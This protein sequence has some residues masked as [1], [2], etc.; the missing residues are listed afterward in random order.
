MAM[1]RW[2]PRV[3][4]LPREEWQSRHRTVTAVVAA[5]VPLLWLYAVHTGRGPAHSTLEVSAVLVA[6]AVAVWGGRRRTRSLAAALGLLICSAV[7]VH[8][9]NGQIE[10]HFHYFVAVALIA[11]YEEWLVY[12]VAVGFVVLQHGIMGSHDPFDVFGE[13]GGSPWV[14]TA[15]HTGFVLCLCAAQ[16]AFWRVNER[17]HARELAVEQARQ[18]SERR[19]QQVIDDSPVGIARVTLTGEYVE[20]NPAMST[21]LGRDATEIVGRDY[22]LFTHPEDL[23]VPAGERT[24]VAVERRTF[25]REKRYVRPDGTE[26]WALVTVSM[27]DDDAGRPAWFLVQAQDVT[28]RRRLRDARLHL[29]LEA[30]GTGSWEW[31]LVAGTVHR[32]ATAARLLGLEADPS[33]PATARLHP[34]DRGHIAAARERAITEDGRFDVEYRVPQPDGSLVWVHSRAELVRDADG[35]PLRLL[36]VSLDVTDRHRA[37]EER[38]ALRAAEQQAAERAIRLQ[39]LTAALAEALTVEE[40]RAALA[41]TAAGM[42]GS[43][44]SAL[45]VFDSSCGRWVG[46]TGSE[47]ELAAPVRDALRDGTPV[48]CP[49]T[50]DQGAAMALPLVGHGVLHGGWELRWPG[51]HVRTPEKERFLTT[52]AA[53]VGTTLERAGL[54]EAQREVAELLQRSLLPDRVPQPDGVVTAARYLPAGRAAQVGGDWYDVI[55]LP[56]GRIG[57]AIGDVSG[58]GVQAAALMGQLRGTLRAYAL[59]GRAPGQVLAAVNRAAASIAG[60]SPEQL[61]TAAYA[62]VDLAAGQVRHARAGHPPLVLVEPDGAA[63]DPRLL[64][65]PAGPPLGVE[66]DAAYPEATADLGNGSWLLGYTDGFVERRDEPFDA[67]LDRLLDALRTS[68][69]SAPDDVLDELLAVVPGPAD[70]DIALIALRTER[71]PAP[72][73]LHLPKPR[74][75]L[76]D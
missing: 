26:V 68:T 12:A 8:L 47:P 71:D 75:G 15:V 13:H 67:G 42:P 76:P 9:S 55:P 39:Q 45:S 17:S 60:L 48:W 49:A 53:L 30:A 3:A 40:V 20:V 51:E 7:V 50:A 5:H 69:R 61:A 4:R 14:S 21:L 10:A 73:L 18:G 62:V 25:Q 65:G 38:A 36:G 58:H 52:A 31:D 72:R 66:E 19:A 54:F 37:E 23:W 2:L 33:G 35:R 74:R 1:A 32:S 24:E 56:D 43:P 46:P 11:L 64:D 27:L 41:Q 44:A 34:D 59:D 22:A 29:A 63:W 16:L 28:E 70:D 57:V 6:L